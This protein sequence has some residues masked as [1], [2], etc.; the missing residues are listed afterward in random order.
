MITVFYD[1]KCGLCRREIDHY[2]HIAPTNVFTWIDITTTP[3]PFT[4]R[5]YNVNDGLKALHV[6]DNSQTMRIGVAAFAVIWT[7]LPRGWP[8]LALLLRIPLVLPL[9]NI[10]YTQFAAWRFKKLGYDSC[11]I[12]KE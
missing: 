6:E 8:V 10:A 12:T 1:G 4:M 5:G 11:S 2:K 9:A 7:Q 3:E